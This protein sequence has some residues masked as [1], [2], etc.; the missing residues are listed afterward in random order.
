MRKTHRL[1]LLWIVR[2]PPWKVKILIRTDR[3]AVRIRKQWETGPVTRGTGRL[4]EFGPS[5]SAG[6]AASGSGVR[7]PALPRSGWRP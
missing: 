1:L 7:G 4:L 6:G 5:G 3:I 2:I